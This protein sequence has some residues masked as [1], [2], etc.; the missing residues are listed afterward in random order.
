MWID[1]LDVVI[2]EIWEEIKPPKFKYRETE[3]LQ[4]EMCGT[5]Y[6]GFAEDQIKAQQ[7]KVKN[8]T[9]K[10]IVIFIHIWEV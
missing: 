3:E 7:Q 1:S 5:W 8:F 6:L 2:G 4:Q 10:V 9:V